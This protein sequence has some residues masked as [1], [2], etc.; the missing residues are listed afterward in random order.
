MISRALKIYRIGPV[1]AD[2]EEIARLLV[3][4]LIR[5]KPLSMGYGVS[6]LYRSDDLR[7]P[8]MLDELKLDAEETHQQRMYTERVIPFDEE[9]MYC[10]SD[11]EISVL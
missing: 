9:K 6:F 7:I 11:D 8:K 10:F 3:A 4:M 2:T 5:S 1:Y